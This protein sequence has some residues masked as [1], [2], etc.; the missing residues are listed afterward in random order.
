MEK[1]KGHIKVDCNLP[2]EYKQVI[3]NGFQGTA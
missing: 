2:T 1:V 3:S